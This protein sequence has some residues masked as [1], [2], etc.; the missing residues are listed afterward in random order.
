MEEGTERGAR[1]EMR[2]LFFGTSEFAIAPLERLLESHFDVV[3]VV[4]TPDKP[5]K[6]GRKLVMSPVKEFCLQEGVDVF[7]PE[8]LKEDGTLE[9]IEKYGADAFVVVSYGKFLPSKLLFMV[10]KRFNI[11]PSLLPLYRGASPIQYALL[12][13]DSYTGVSIIDITDKMDAGDIY[14]QWVERIRKEDNYLSLSERLSKIGAEM[15]LCCLEFSLQ[16]SL[17][18]KRQNEERA[19]YTKI[20]KKSDGRIDF[21]SMSSRRVVNMVRAFYP[22]PGAYFIHKGKQF[23]IIKAHEA[24]IR[25]EAGKVLKVSKSE[26]VIGCLDG[27]ISIDEIQPESKKPMS[28]RAFL[29]GYRFEVGEIIG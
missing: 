17:K 19:T 5:G 16:G 29:A 2:I 10:E 26:L 25:G 22:W 23:K 3:G 27:A 28:I 13:G 4:T 9:T 11:H 7:Q 8:S 24:N 12:N 1:R 18:P 6:R 15:L 21:S 20:I 14:M